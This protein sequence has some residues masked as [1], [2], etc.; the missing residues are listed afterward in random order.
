MKKDETR[1]ARRKNGWMKKKILLL[2]A[3]KNS[4]TSPILIWKLRFCHHFSVGLFYFIFLYFCVCF[5]LLLL[6]ASCYL[7]ALAATT[8]RFIILYGWVCVRVCDCIFTNAIKRN[9]RKKAT[10]KL[11][12]NSSNQ[13]LKATKGTEQKMNGGSHSNGEIKRIYDATD[14]KHS[15]NIKI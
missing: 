3:Y 1:T 2:K 11:N 6:L 15:T 13:C 4:Y 12:R 10:I 5:A 7:H 8:Q 14:E 9:Q